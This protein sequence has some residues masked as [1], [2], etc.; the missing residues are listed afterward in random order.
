MKERMVAFYISRDIIN[1][2]TNG[3]VEWTFKSQA[4]TYLSIQ[5][6]DGS[7]ADVDYAN[8]TSSANG[9]AWSPYLAL[10]RMQAM[11]QAFADPSS[12]SY[13]SEALL[14]GIQKGLDYWFTALPTSTNW[15]ETGIGKQ[16]RLAKI[17]IL[18]E[19][20]LT[21]TQAANII[22]T[23]D[24]EPNTVDGANSSWYNQNYMIRGLLLEDVRIV[25]SAVNA[26]NVLSN[27]TTTVT[28]IQSD[29]SF[30]MH[31]KTNYTTGYGRSFARDMS[32]WAYVTS[33]T[34]FSYSK[35]AIDSLSSYL[36]DG[37]RYLVRGDVADLGM[38]M[39]GPEWPGYE[40]SALTF[41]EDPLQWM[42]TA[43]P[44]RAAEFASFLHN[45]REVGTST[46]NGQIANNTTQWQT[47]VSSHMRND[48]GITVKMAS[49]TVKGGE[50]RTINPGGYNLLYWT[51]QGA[52]AIQRTGDEYRTI[53]PLMNWAHVPGTTAPNV[54]TKDGNFNNPK[55]FVGGVTNERYGA[56]AFDF[57]KLSTSGKKGYFFFDDEMVALGAGITSTNAAAV[58]TTLNQSRAVGQAL[59]DG[60]PIA[61]G[62]LQTTGR[63]AYNDSIGYVFP[64]ATTFQVNRE[65]KTGSWSDVVT[66]S[67]TEPITESIFSIWLDHGVKPTNAS[68]QYIVLPNKSS[69]EV[70]DYAGNI[71]VTI[72]SNTP[73]IQAVRHNT[74]NI[75]EML[76]YKAGTV[77][78]RDGLTVK[79]D[80]PS[81][82]IVDESVT[83]A[84]ISVSNPETP[85]MIVNVTLDRNGVT[86]T[87]SY[88]LGKDTFTG[89]SVTMNE[90]ASIDDRGFDLAYDKGA[91]A[92][93]SKNGHASSHATDMY[94]TSYWSSNDSDNEW[95]SV[96][97]QDQYVIDRVRLSW[98]NA[99]GKSYKIQVS[100]DAVTWRDVYSTTTGDGAIDEISFRSISARYVRM[101]GVQQGTGNG[102]SLSEFKAY[103]ALPPNLA[104]GKTIV[105]SS[106]RAADVA[107]GNAV[108]GIANTRWGSNYSDA[109]WAYVDLGAS[110]M[111]QKVVLRWESYGKEFEIRVSDDL[112]NWNT[113]YSTANGA[114]GTDTITFE[115]VQARYVQMYGIKRGTTY[116]YSLWEFEAYGSLPPNLAEGM[117]ATA[118]SA[119]ASDVAAGSAVDGLLNTRWGSNY[120]DSQW[121]YV[122]LGYSKPIDKVDLHWESAYGKEY[123][124]RVSDDAA[125]WTT[126]YST[127]TGA[128]GVEKIAFAPVN[129][130]YVQMFGTKRGSSYGYSL[131]EFKVYSPLVTFPDAPVDVQAIGRDGS[132]EVSFAAPI[133]NGGSDIVRYTA[134][135]WLNGTAVSSE[136]GN[137]SPITIAGLTNG[138][139]Y[140]ITVVAT[141]AIGDS[142]P[143]APISVTPTLG[144]PSAPQ[145]PASLTSVAGDALVTLNWSVSD[146]A[147][148]YSVY[149]YEGTA[150]PVDPG[151][152]AIVQASVTG[153]T[154][155][156]TDLTN[157]TSYAFA[158]KA[159]NAGGESGFSDA[160]IAT[161][162]SELPP[163]PSAPAGLT[164]VAGDGRVALHWNAVTGAASYDVYRYEGAEAPADP[165]DWELVRSGVVLD[166]YTVT[167]LTNGTSYA[168]AVKAINASGNSGFSGETIA[169][170]A[171]ELPQ[172]PAAPGS[173]TGTAGDGRVVLA[174]S[175]AAGADSYSI[176]MHEGTSAPVDPSSWALVQAGVTT[177]TYTANG[178]TNGTT[179]AFAVQAVNAGGGS[180]FSAAAIAT[181]GA[182]TTGN[183]DGGG[184]SGNNGSGTDTSVIT[185]TN[186]SILIPSSRAGEVSLDNEVSLAIGAGA[187]EQELRIEIVK[188]LDIANLAFDRET[189]V[190]NVFEL[191]KNVT[192]NFKRPIVI[193]MK[194]DPSLV[195][196][197]QK[198]AIYYYDEVNQA[199]I[200][201][202]GVVNGDRITTEV[203]HFTKFAVMAV[204]EKDEGG[205]PNTPAPSFT[206]IAGHWA[207]NDILNAASK[208]LVSGYPDGTFQPNADITRAD[209]TVMLAN[210]L[211]LQAAS[212]MAAFTDE[213]R[214]GGWAKQAIASAAEAGIVSGYADGS[215]RPDARITR[216]EL[217]AMVARVLKLSAEAGAKTGFSDDK[218]I[219]DWA[220][221]A[222]EAVR[223]LG[224]ASGRGDNKFVPNG[225]ATRA[226]AVTLL[227][228]MLKQVTER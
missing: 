30:F 88:K 219:P 214:I 54:L 55:T 187:A 99:Y 160:T 142:D 104:E 1:D 192:G 69:A 208:R 5:N 157:G 15:W 175:A 216:A 176:Y 20:Y 122:D 17:A 80:Q 19:G 121:I 9:R 177:V 162:T 38:G 95:I 12:P 4:G 200:E 113:V 193:S 92:S 199:W 41:Y 223:K 87:T 130:R 132:A 106:S 42:L 27:V 116:G 131:W 63:W 51:N 53:Y 62:P 158:V 84:R 25:R 78:V 190:S 10:D 107:A 141:N 129:A 52:T 37:T 108:D 155:D 40:S 21:E 102:Y 117:P 211:K 97:L 136:Q 81:M 126:V 139:T 24:R 91:T 167:G 207:M 224:L 58:H 79:V 161:P 137:V 226:E 143:S 90:G 128:G 140:D 101:Q 170:P 49:S 225:T 26:F 197:D 198:V 144:L 227:V 215:F 184:N 134:T 50:W 94:R 221:G 165:G 18:C 112:T 114:G 153:A 60:N 82:V 61:D 47:L 8:T 23:L 183:P 14:A 16:L 151:D 43:N 166:T 56:T 57:N 13:H 77:T 171:A 212:S 67:S 152:W 147:V 75:V 48:Y 127:T 100:N 191:T 218:D 169:A 204:G 11:A 68:Y 159:A 93:S 196:D 45:I 228:R 189:L 149:K 109:Q 22:D 105:A 188:L 83:P 185:S 3:R 220:K 133:R 32:F 206:D 33:G 44:E 178:L 118:S 195:G 76:F 96:D 202:G 2:G 174:W 36:L 213:A 74:L 98:E 209:F 7:W 148:S 210:A 182:P 124:I 110:Q 73:S 180:G 146:G 222:I 120:S 111:I 64:T 123:Q 72:L 103:E 66:G 156:V 6:A 138:E 172:A 28:G 39:N 194:F 145:A 201:I 115:P 70:G 168:F 65:T 85:G 29:M 125:N 203:D 59:V 31:G 164:S 154:Y 205:E 34:V 135:A 89:R 173:L 119:R 86:T 217:A 179:Y 71:P 181:P 163:A 150:A 46:S 35:A 186:G